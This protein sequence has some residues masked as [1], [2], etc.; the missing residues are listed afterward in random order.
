MDMVERA[1]SSCLNAKL[2]VTQAVN[3]LVRCIC[4]HVFFCDYKG[5]EKKTENGKKMYVHTSNHRRF[6]NVRP[7]EFIQFI[8]HPLKRQFVVKKRKDKIKRKEKKRKKIQGKERKE[9]KRKEKKRKEKKRK[10]KKRKEKEKE[11]QPEQP[12]LE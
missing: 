11:K 6:K 5:E 7:V 8:I 2:A 4:S 9:K 10:E 1:G 12:S 3:P